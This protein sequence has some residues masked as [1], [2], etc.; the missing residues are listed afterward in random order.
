MSGERA[1]LEAEFNRFG[2]GALRTL[3]RSIEAVR[4]GSVA[5]HGGRSTLA[6]GSA[7]VGL[8]AGVVL[9][10]VCSSLFVPKVAVAVL[11]V[12]FGV[13]TCD[14]YDE[15]R[16][17]DWMR[18]KALVD[19]I[20]SLR[21]SYMMRAGIFRSDTDADSRFE[22]EMLRI[23]LD[24]TERVSHLSA[25][26]PLGAGTIS[27][28]MSDVRANGIRER[29]ERYRR[30]RAPIMID[31]WN[32]Q[33]TTLANASQVW[34]WFNVVSLAALYIT[35]AV[36]VMFYESTRAVL[37]AVPMVMVA[38]AGGALQLRSCFRIGCCCKVVGEALTQHIDALE[39]VTDEARLAVLVEQTENLA[40]E[41]S[42]NQVR[43]WLAQIAIPDSDTISRT[44]IRILRD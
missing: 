8:G 38:I 17:N 6:A 36:G 11:L 21:W 44:D 20:T 4:L 15:V 26:P 40:S 5:P 30:D 1:G 7:L 33:M 31:V 10:G 32:H 29:K 42:A 37:V 23:G 2:E 22:K 43:C 9:V 13:V 41:L 25:L 34:I 19:D 12:V 28:S 35:L 39:S 24:A 16:R 27:R 14:L 18:C 3:L